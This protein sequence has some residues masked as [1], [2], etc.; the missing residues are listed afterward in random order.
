MHALLGFLGRG[1]G[2]IEQMASKSPFPG[3]DPWLES[4]W[5]DM[6]AALVGYA[7][8]AIKPQ[9]PTGLHAR[10]QQRVFVEAIDERLG[11]RFPDLHIIARP[12]PFS[13]GE[14]SVGNGGVATAP[15]RVRMLHDPVTQGFIHIADASGTVIT[16][17]EFL[18]PSNKVAGKG[19]QLYLE[20]Q[21]QLR[22]GGVNLVEIDLVRTG[23]RV[24][25]I[26]P[27]Q[28]SPSNQTPY[29]AIVSR[30]SDPE[31]AE[32]YPISLREQLPSISIPLRKSDADVTLSLQSLIEKAY[33]FGGYESTD[34]T[35]PAI[36]ALVG[37][38]AIWAAELLR[39][40]G[41]V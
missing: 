15:L 31:W 9:L 39:T 20:R 13:E 35:K 22:D 14:R 25:M 26:T 38:D 32:V 21:K 27:E 28:L 17:V 18:S 2:R 37:P 11:T 34:Y 6:H 33:E 24:T 12:T 36:P 30:A 29:Y 4:T 10:I 23:E 40:A 19:Q 3:M 7:R 8:D 41:R 1:C 5:G 16:A